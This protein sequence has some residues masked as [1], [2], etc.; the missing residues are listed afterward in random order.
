M[1]FKFEDLSENDN[2]NDKDIFDVPIAPI[3]TLS[4]L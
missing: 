4:S 1:K 3:Q 2:E